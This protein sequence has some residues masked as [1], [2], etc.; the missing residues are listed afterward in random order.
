MAGASPSL[1][2]LSFFLKKKKKQDSVVWEYGWVLNTVV[3]RQVIGLTF[4]II[5]KKHDVLQL[6]EADK[7]RACFGWRSRSSSV[8]RSF[9]RLCLRGLP[10]YVF[11]S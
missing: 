3:I 6:R 4:T 1:Q 7:A 8:D 11:A 10:V 5:N 2:L 9:V